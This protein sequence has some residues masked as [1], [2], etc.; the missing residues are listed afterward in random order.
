MNDAMK[1]LLILFAL[2]IA[3]GAQAQEKMII[4]ETFET[5]RLRW[6]EAFEKDYSIGLM[7]GYFELKNN[8]KDYLIRTVTELPINPEANFKVTS[9]FTVPKFNDDCY[10]GIIFNYEDENNYSYFLVTEKKFKLYNRVNGEVSL[11]RQNSIILN[12]GKNKEIVIDME[13]KGR[14]LIFNVDEMEA[15]TITKDMKYN[16]FGFIVVD[17]NTVKVNEVII[18]QMVDD[19]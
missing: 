14:K 8:R 9:K 10:F 17:D 2:L 3:A 4:R 12:A 13:K 18:E 19:E 11:S 15:I 16:T 7:D 1:K 6:D 5:N